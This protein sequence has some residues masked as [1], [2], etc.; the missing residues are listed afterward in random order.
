MSLY[1]DKYNPK[2]FDE[3]LFNK[4]AVEKLKNI[5]QFNNISHILIT[6]CVGS[7]RN[8]LANLYLDYKYKKKIIDISGLFKINIRLSNPSSAAKKPRCM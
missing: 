3:I 2:S 4:D 7:G 1:I 6:G 5:S 8:T